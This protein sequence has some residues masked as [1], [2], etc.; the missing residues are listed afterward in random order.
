M[1]ELQLLMLNLPTTVHSKTIVAIEMPDDK[2]RYTVSGV[3]YDEK[4]D[5]VIIEVA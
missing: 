4:N 1:L 2:S 5:S 3:R